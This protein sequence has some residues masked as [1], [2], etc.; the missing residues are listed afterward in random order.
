[1]NQPQ[2]ER[3]PLR[4][5]RSECYVAGVAGGLGRWLGV[6]PAV[7]RVAFV[8]LT[9][10]GGSGLVIYAA[11]WLLLPGEADGGGETAPI[12]RRWLAATDGRP[13]VR[14]L[15]LVAAVIAALSALGEHGSFTSLVA[16]LLIGAGAVLVFVDRDAPRAA[17][18]AAPAAPAAAVAATPSAQATPQSLHAAIARG[19]YANAM[20][21]IEQG[22][23]I[24]AKD[25]GA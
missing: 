21:M 7:V 12:A 10:I 23:D 19:D 3:P 11:G 4:R 22:A 6:D 17:A 1:M 8:V 15:L 5:S 2:V 13:A 14:A 18:P 25:P 16:L 9:V 24:E 20:K